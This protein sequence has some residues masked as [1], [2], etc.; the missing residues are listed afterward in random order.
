MMER[1]RKALSRRDAPNAELSWHRHHS[2]YCGDVDHG[3]CVIYAVVFGMLGDVAEAYNGRK[4]LNDHATGTM[5]LLGA[6][7]TAER[8]PY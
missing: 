2:N 8:F 6:H 1:L 5:M 4:G 3:M 7:L